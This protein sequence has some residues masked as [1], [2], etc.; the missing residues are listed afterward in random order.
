M[1]DVSKAPPKL[2]KGSFGNN[3]V[4]QHNNLITACY[5]LT[6]TEKKLL[7]GCICKINSSEVISSETPF[8]FDVNEAGDILG[9]DLTNTGAVDRFRKAAK[10][11]MTKLVTNDT[12][13]G[14]IDTTFAQTAEFN[15]IEK[16]MT[17]YF[18]KGMIPYLSDLHSQFTQYRIIHVGKLDSKHAIRLYELLVMWN[19]QN[20]SKDKNNYKKFTVDEFAKIMG[21]GESY[22]SVIWMFKQRVIEPACE[23]INKETDITIDIKFRKSGKKYTHVELYFSMDDQWIESEREFKQI[24]NDDQIKKITDSMDFLHTYYQSY[25]DKGGKDGISGFITEAKKMLKENPKKHFSDYADYLK[26]K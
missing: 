13:D 1:K 24:L 7:L 25:Q 9:V 21:G 19:G 26:D 16:I 11:L 2:K 23:Q 8:R 18:S 17:I 3:L 20:Y 12:A 5:N 4:S 15:S 22:K 10:G 6:V 14:W